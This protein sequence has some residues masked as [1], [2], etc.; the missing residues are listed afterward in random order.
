MSNGSKQE[1][2]RAIQPRYYSSGKEEKKKILDEF[3]S[4]CNYNRK[5]A[6]RLLNTKEK[7]KRKKAGRK[8]KY[9]KPDLVDF[10]KKVWTSS[11]LICSR[12]IKSLIPLWLPFYKGK[13][14]E[15]EKELLLSISPS[16]IDRLLKPI[17]TKYNKVGLATTRPGTLIRK[18][19]PIKTNQWDE[20]RPGFIEAD[21][22]AHC[23]GSVSGQFVYTVN[24]V[25][26]A[27]GWIESRAMWGK[28][29]K[30]CFEAIR[31]IEE[32]LPF[33]ILGFDSDNGG[34]FLNWHLHSYFTKRRKPVDYSRSRAYHKNDNAHIEGKNWTHIRQ[35]LGYMR[36]ENPDMVE[37]I[38]DLYRNEWTLF[39]NFFI[40]SAKIVEKKRVG[41]KQVKRYDQPQTPFQRLKGTGI[42]TKKKTKELE[43]VLTKIDPFKL[44]EN[45][46][47]KI[48]E[49][50]KHAQV[51]SSND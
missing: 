47:T 11:N 27:T 6:I 43:S 18:E 46:K 20:N 13:L 29:Q 9:N 23:G 41:A 5:Y 3:C 10:I 12:R 33:K 25:D 40:P 16:T 8:K 28:G 49:I 36:F 22:V 48:K 17:R 14:T 7:K 39:F 4:T 15:E 44:Q 31:S 24:T 26:I 19:V 30:G 45:I 34:E 21:S 35:Y 42:L 1:Y 2:L 38:N 32:N 37:M 50:L 51:E